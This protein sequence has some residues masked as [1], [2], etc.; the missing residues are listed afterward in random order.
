MKKLIVIVVSPSL[1]SVSCLFTLSQRTRQVQLTCQCP[2]LAEPDDYVHIVLYTACP[3]STTQPSFHTQLETVVEK[4]T[5][6]ILLSITA[7]MYK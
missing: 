4:I 5:N 6:Y 2:A 3:L 1:L 7:E